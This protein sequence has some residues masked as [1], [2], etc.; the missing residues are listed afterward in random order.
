MILLDDLQDSEKA[1]SPEQVRKLL[2]IIRSDVMNLG[3]KGRASIICT[4]TPIA[5]DDLTM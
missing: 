2:D 4:A 5:V 3:G 1:N